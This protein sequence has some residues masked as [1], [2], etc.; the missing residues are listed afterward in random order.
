MKAWLAKAWEWIVVQRTRLFN[1]IG[2]GVVLL[3]P[4]LG[5][6]EIQA[7]IPK[8]YMP[9]VIAGVFLI[10]LWMRP[11]PAVVKQK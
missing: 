5:A 4:V 1:L 3:A 7:V 2:A 11:R 9:Y 10:N 6:P 8:Q